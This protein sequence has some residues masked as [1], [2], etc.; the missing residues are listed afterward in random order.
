MVESPVDELDETYQTQ[1]GSHEISNSAKKS[2]HESLLSVRALPSEAFDTAKTPSKGEVPCPAGFLGMMVQRT[3]ELLHL[4]AQCHTPSVSPPKPQAA[5]KCGGVAAH[6]TSTCFCYK[7]KYLQNLESNWFVP[8]EWGLKAGKNPIVTSHVA[9]GG[10]QAG[11]NNLAMLMKDSKC[12]RGTNIAISVDV[13]VNALSGGGIILRARSPV[14]FYE[15]SIEHDSKSTIMLRVIKG[16]K[17]TELHVGAYDG[18]LVPGLWVPLMVADKG[19]S[20]EVFIGTQKVIDVPVD[21]ESQG[22]RLGLINSGGNVDF[23]KF[24]IDLL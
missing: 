15:V 18:N 7:E 14:D 4:S 2:H 22:G 9:S 5:L 3:K 13:K 6:V 21:P 20:M 16:T 10:A 24:A 8:S 19:T 17:P 1:K 12:P 11:A 23:D